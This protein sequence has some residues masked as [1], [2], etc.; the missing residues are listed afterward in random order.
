[1]DK[2]IKNGHLEEAKEYSSILALKGMDFLKTAL[3]IEAESQGIKKIFLRVI[4]MSGKEVFSSDISAWDHIKISEKAI[5][6]IRNGKKVRPKIILIPGIRKKVM[7]SYQLIG[8]DLILQIAESIKD[9]QKYLQLFRNTFWGIMILMI[10]LSLVVGWTMFRRSLKGVEMVT[11]TAEDITMGDLK[12]RVRIKPGGI[13]IEHLANT[14]NNM[15]D[16]IDKL[17]FG[18]KEVTDNIAHD[19]KIPITRIRGLAEVT[20]NIG[21]G[22]E[23]YEEMAASTIEECDHLLQLINTLLDISERK[24]GVITPT[25]TEFDIVPSIHRIYELFLPLAEQK[26]LALTVQLPDTCIITG[27]AMEIQRLIINILDNAFKYTPSNGNISIIV[28]KMNDKVQISI[29]DTGIGIP[30]DDL[31][32][33]FKRFYRC[34]RSRSEEGFGLGLS[35]AQTIAKYHGGEI[36]VDSTPGK[37]STFT[38]VLNRHLPE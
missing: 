24:A 2:N 32:F 1:M 26:D 21:Q 23:R 13:E 37:G 18:M 29:M 5:E 30:K 6:T 34:D 28:D 22:D 20:L 33:I 12:K 8:P 25:F 17:I 11:K 35:L 38:I 4:D 36:V 19:L 14:F 10:F 27:D 9:S 31:P 3:Q 16:R 7:V 15:I